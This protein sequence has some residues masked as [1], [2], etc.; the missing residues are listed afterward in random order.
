[1]E[2]ADDNPEQYWLDSA[3]HERIF[4][5]D[6]LFRE[7]RRLETVAHPSLEYFAGQPGAGKSH[8]QGRVIAELQRTSGTHSVMSIV[9]DDL[10]SYHPT[11]AR[12]QQQNDE[13]AAFLTDHD[14]GLWVERAIAASL[15]TRPHVILEGTFRRADVVQQTVS[16]HQQ[17]G[18]ERHLHVMA[19]HQFVSRT[20]IIGRYLLQ[21][22]NEGLGRYTNRQAH[23]AAYEAL[24][25]SLEVVA[26]LF[27]KVTVYGGNGTVLGGV[28]INT[29]GAS[30]KVRELLDHER[31]APSTPPNDLQERLGEYEDLAR[32]YERQE[33]LDD[34]LQLERDLQGRRSR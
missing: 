19:V 25:T 15:Q 5:E 30:E 26:H 29:P 1:M 21:V 8:L 10:R 31:A 2:S 27:D 24:P 7:Y 28:T 14:T 23:D 18:F 32:R 17:A 4:R 12:L 20:R 3:E 16:Q 33:C 34:I 13:R 9:G 6:I 22:R 11:Y